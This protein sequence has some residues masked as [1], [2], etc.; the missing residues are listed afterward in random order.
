MKKVEATLPDN[1]PKKEFANKKA[2]FECKI[3]GLKKP[4]PIK[5]DDNFSKGLGAKDLDD[6]KKLIYQQI[7][8]QYKHTFESILK[9][10]ILNHLDD[11]YD[12]DLPDN[13]IEQE[14]VLLSQGSKKEDLDK[15]KIEKEKIE[16]E[17]IAK[18]RIKLGLILNEIGEKNNL[19][20]SED[21]IK[22]EVQKQIQSMP[23]Q[24]KQILEYYQNNPS[25][26]ESLKGS[27]Y[28][29][30]II[31]LIIEKGKKTKKTISTKEAEEIIKNVHTEKKAL[32]KNVKSVK[33]LKAKKAHKKTK[34]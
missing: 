12:I 21:E 11:E 3:V 20:V 22:N 32:K 27:I 18:K 2:F 6:L 5:V 26:T 9:E 10:K 25:A 13:L 31:A 8:N 19:K 28:E 33:Q 17:K 24:S 16:K 23:G 34:K 29:E 15:E 14:M 1:Y 30:K 7:Q 4:M